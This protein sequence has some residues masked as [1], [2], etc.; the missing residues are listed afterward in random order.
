MGVRFDWDFAKAE[1]NVRKHGVAFTEAQTVFGDPGAI[2]VFDQEHSVQEER[3]VTL[4]LSVIGRLV[5][6]V[7]TEREDEQGNEVWW[8]ISARRAT[9]REERDYGKE[10]KDRS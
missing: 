1:S 6:V 9:R 7:H 2:T 4:G 5:V 8:L 10:N 3:F